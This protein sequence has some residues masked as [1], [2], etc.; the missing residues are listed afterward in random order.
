MVLISGGRV[1]TTEIYITT[2]KSHHEL[3]VQTIELTQNP[4]DP[5]LENQKTSL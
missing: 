2:P 1:F 4:H 3:N 5:L